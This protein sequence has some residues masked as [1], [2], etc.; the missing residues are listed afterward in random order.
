VKEIS[1]SAWLV[2]AFEL[3]NKRPVVWLGSV[4]FLAVLM[5]LARVSLALGILFSISSLFIGVGVV[6]A[7]HRETES[8]W[9]AIKKQIPLALMLAVILMV[10]WFVFRLLANINSGEMEK[11]LQFFFYWELTEDNFQGKVFRQLIVWLYSAAIVALIF[12][13]LMLNSFGSWFSY[14]LMVFK[15]CSW[16]EARELG[17]QASSENA[18]VMYKLTGFLLLTAFVGMGLIPL[19]TPLFY[20]LVSTLMYVSYHDIFVKK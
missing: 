6:D 15:Q 18:S 5:P 10:F 12:V 1:F 7:I 14:P 13:L 9:A 3:A 19:L 20:M 11:I 2:Q 16:G 4:L 17:K 8:L